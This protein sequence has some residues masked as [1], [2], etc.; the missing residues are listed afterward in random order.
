MLNYFEW[1]ARYNLNRLK[2]QFV[3][4][5]LHSG[6]SLDK[7]LQTWAMGV[8]KSHLADLPSSANVASAQVGVLASALSDVGGHTLCVRR[9][10]QSLHDK[11]SLALFLSDEDRAERAASVTLAEAKSVA[12]VQGGS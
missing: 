4:T 11:Y 6:N 1:A 9:L 12:T 3:T 5:D 8:W 7:K 10:L 2:R